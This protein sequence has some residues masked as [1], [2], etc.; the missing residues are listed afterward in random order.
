MTVDIHAIFR[1][2]RHGTLFLEQHLP[3]SIRRVTFSR[4]LEREADYGNGLGIVTIE[5]SRT[6]VHRA[7]GGGTIHSAER[8]LSS[9]YSRSNA[10]LIERRVGTLVS[11]VGNVDKRKLHCCLPMLIYI[12]HLA[13]TISMHRMSYHPVT[14]RGTGD[15]VACS[16][17]HPPTCGVEVDPMVLS[18]ASDHPHHTRIPHD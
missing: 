15:R 9:V 8:P 7:G 6:G 11:S 13:G 16:H 10:L 14:H 2:L 5:L 4:K 18:K 17:A 1:E 12:R 3:E